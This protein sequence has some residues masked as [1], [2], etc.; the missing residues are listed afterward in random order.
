MVMAYRSC[1]L[2][3]NRF[4]SL[5][6]FMICIQFV[7]DVGTCDFSFLGNLFAF[8]VLI[9]WLAYGILGQ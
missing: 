9:G 2:K 6:Y 7:V 5:R 1:F 4:S 3:I 8:P